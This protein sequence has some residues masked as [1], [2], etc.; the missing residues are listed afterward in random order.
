MN[1]NF[2]FKQMAQIA[3]AT[4]LGVIVGQAFVRA[5]APKQPVIVNC[6]AVKV[7]EQQP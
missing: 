4:M 7:V 6:P 1:W 3:G 5:Y 2:T